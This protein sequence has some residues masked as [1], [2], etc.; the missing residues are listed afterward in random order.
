MVLVSQQYLCAGATRGTIR[1][2]APSV[3]VRQ[4]AAHRR[5]RVLREAVLQFQ[6]ARAFV[7]GFTVL[8]VRRR[9]IGATCAQSV[10]GEGLGTLK[11][12]MQ[13]SGESTASR[14]ARAA[15]AAYRSEFTDGPI[16][17]EWLGMY[18][19]DVVPLDVRTR[20]SYD[21]FASAVESAAGAE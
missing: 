16:D 18:Y 17:A 13:G 11:Q 7:R 21:A 6:H 9:T 2:L 20:L 14:Y 4:R 19:A 15:I 5:G 1:V 3:A 8:P 12:W 10:S